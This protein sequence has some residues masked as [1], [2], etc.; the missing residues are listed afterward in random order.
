MYEKIRRRVFEIIEKG[1]DHDIVSRIFDAF[2][3][4]LIIL[5]ILSVFFETF[6]ISKNYKFILSK[7]E[8][9]SIIIFTIEYLCRIWTADFLNKDEKRFKARIK[10]IFSFMALIDLLSIIPFYVPFII[11]IDL[12]ILRILR[13]FRIMRIVKL[14]RYTSSLKRILNV[15]KDKYYELVSAVFILAILMLIS[16]I[17]IYY[18]ESPYQP[19][20]YKNA[21]SG[22][23]W[24]LAVFT[25]VWLG[26][27]YPITALGRVFCGLTAIFGVAIIAVPTG[28]ITSGFS[29][30][31]ES[32]EANAEANKE[33]LRLLYELKEEITELKKNQ[34]K[35][36]EKK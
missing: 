28:I 1:E 33:Q 24:S 19:E 18:I 34:E 25:S 31:K 7:F 2:I 27:V 14:N 5:N 30:D 22:L 10:Y 9:V 36:N 16:S 3:S 21:L 17:L 4:I 23:W 8:L 26:D 12:R 13:L 29:E 20:V 32:T 6:D 11:V 35:Q 15:I